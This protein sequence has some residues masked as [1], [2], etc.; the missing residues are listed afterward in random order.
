MEYID[1][2]NSENTQDRIDQYLDNTMSNE[3]RAIIENELAS[4]PEFKNLVEINKASRAAI[5]ELALQ[6]R[7]ANL[8]AHAEAHPINVEQANKNNTSRLILYASLFFILAIALYFS[9]KSNTTRVSTIVAPP[10]TSPPPS[11]VP[12]VQQVEKTFDDNVSPKGDTGINEKI[13]KPKQPVIDYAQLAKKYFISPKN[14]ASILRGSTES[15]VSQAVLEYEK[16][17]YADALSLVNNLSVDDQQSQYIKAH[18]LLK[19]NRSKEASSI[20]QSF[21]DDSMS[22]YHH[23]SSYYLLLCYLQER[24]FEKTKT[25]NLAKKIVLQDTEYKNET[26]KILGELEK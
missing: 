6:T 17:N 14:I 21:E 2:T 20:F 7:L 10:S 26:I 8:K 4:N 16:G 9:F 5:K 22:D 1:I 23:T 15:T 12:V 18:S 19:L 24:P 3:E 13:D 11:N 25:L